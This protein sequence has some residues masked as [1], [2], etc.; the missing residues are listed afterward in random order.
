MMKSLGLVAA[1]LF[2]ASALAPA[3]NAQSDAPPA[4]IQPLSPD[5]VAEVQ[6][7]LAD[8]GVYRGAADGVWGPDSQDALEEFQRTRGLQ[9]TGELNQATVA[10]MGLDAFELLEL[11]GVRPGQP[12]AVQPIAGE[13]LEPDAVRVIQ[14]QLQELGFYRGET[15]GVWGALTQEAIE[16]FQEDRGL[17]VTG[18]LDANTVTT[19]G[20]DPEAVMPGNR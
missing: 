3:S 9:A 15:D 13:E 16:R 11:S 20:L 5:A 2:G 19:M 4:Y 7:V 17:R 1:V 18:Q 14:G 6:R 12:Q 10:T 8:L